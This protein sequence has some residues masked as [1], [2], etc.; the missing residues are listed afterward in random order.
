[1]NWDVPMLIACIAVGGAIGAV[2]RA[3]LRYVVA[4]YPY[5]SEFPWGTFLVNMVGCTLLTFVAFSLSGNMSK[6]MELFLF[7]G[8][9]GG[10]TTMST[11]TLETVNLFYE[12]EMLKAAWN[13]ILNGGGC[14]LGAFAGR[15]LALLV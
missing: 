5:M 3:V 14:L 2:L 15:F 7:T 12:N 4:Q 8:V 6:N 10:F 13:V 11:F 1:M 9:F